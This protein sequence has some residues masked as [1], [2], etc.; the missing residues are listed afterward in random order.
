MDMPLGFTHSLAL[1]SYL[2]PG[3]QSRRV[4]AGM[5]VVDSTRESRINCYWQESA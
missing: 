2:T 1:P 3:A 5:R 4:D